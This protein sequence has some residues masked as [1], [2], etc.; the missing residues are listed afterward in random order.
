MTG[1]IPP[2]W[3]VSIPTFNSGAY[4]EEALSSVLIQDPGPDVMQIQVVDDH[5][6]MDDPQATVER[7]GRGRVEFHRQPANVGHVPNFGTCIRR[8]RGTLVHLLHADDRV[9][10]GFYSALQRGFERR[11]TGAAF[12]RQ[13]YVDARGAT[14]GTSSLVAPR[15]GVLHD[16][17]ERI[18]S[19]S[20]IQASSMVVRRTVFDDV[21]GFDER[22]HVCAEDW[23]LW[24]RIAARYEVW[25][26]PETLAEYRAAPESLTARSLITGEYLDDLRLA[27]EIAAS[28][29]PPDRAARLEHAARTSF[30]RVA[31]FAARRLFAQGVPGA[32]FRHVRGA[33]ALRPS[34][35]ALPQF[36]AAAL[37]AAAWAGRSLAGG[38]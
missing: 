23:E 5:S 32:A 7:L 10:P 28:R 33:L 35:R 8:S 20:I 27:V 3:S 30:A 4:L 37:A 16:A 14:T 38:R 24:L 21:G 2:L 17:L 11:T 19:G 29:F 18:A 9:R 22:F 13:A 15:P 12:C 25:F 6:T 31:L 26:E 1:A 34:V 36:G